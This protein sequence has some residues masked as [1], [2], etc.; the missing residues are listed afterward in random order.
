MD[1]IGHSMGSDAIQNICCAMLKKQTIQ[2]RRAITVGTPFYSQSIANIPKES[3]DIIG[4]KDC[5]SER[6]SILQNNRQIKIKT[7]HLS[8]LF[9]HKSLH[10][11]TQLLTHLTH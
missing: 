5:L 10:T 7:G 8:L 4:T 9:H 3:F 2:I 1:L 11:M 6:E